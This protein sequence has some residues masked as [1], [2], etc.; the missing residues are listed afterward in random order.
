MENNFKIIVNDTSEYIF[1]SSHTENLDLL[2]LSKTEFHVIEKNKPYFIKVEKHNFSKK[3]YAIK[4]NSNNYNINISNQLDILIEEMG[5][6]LSST[7]KSNDIKAPMPG[8][9]LN[10]NVKEGQNVIE[11]DTLLILEAMKMENTITAPK[12]GVIKSITV[13]KGVIVQK[14]ELMIIMA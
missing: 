3:E 8:L 9:I 4:I 7:I 10:L 2:K 12:S 5:F 13:S 6:S 11:G 14:G 1:K